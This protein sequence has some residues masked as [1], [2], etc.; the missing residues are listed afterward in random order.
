MILYEQRQMY[1][2][3][4]GK[5][6][7]TKLV[8]VDHICDY[9]G[10]LFSDND[11]YYEQPIWRYDILETGD[12]EP[13]FHNELVTYGKYVIDPYSIFA[14]PFILCDPGISECEREVIKRAF[15]E[16]YTSFYY[17]MIDFRISTV[18][19]LLKEYSL[20]QLGLEY[21]A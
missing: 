13:Q 12:I 5:P 8:M 18:K 9:C 19:N 10:A 11:I 4:T 14:T 17:A 7:F 15:G 21:K 3:T 16:G 1:S 2:R 6:E 20:E